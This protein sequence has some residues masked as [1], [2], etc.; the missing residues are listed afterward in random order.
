M[1]RESLLTLLI[2]LNKNVHLIST[3]TLSWC[4]TFGNAKESFALHSLNQHL[5]AASDV[6]AWMELIGV[7][8][9]TSEHVIM[10]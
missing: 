4:F 1:S 2:W 8:K 3:L 10:G 5:F 7:V 6:D 9:A